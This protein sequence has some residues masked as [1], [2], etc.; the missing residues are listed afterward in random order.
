MSITQYSS[1]KMKSYFR[2]IVSIFLFLS[3]FIPP[4]VFSSPIGKSSNSQ[5]SFVHSQKSK[6]SSPNSSFEPFECD[7]DGSREKSFLEFSLVFVGLLEPLLT[8]RDHSKWQCHIQ[9]NSFTEN[10]SRR[11]TIRHS[12]N[13]PPIS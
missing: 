1:A 5:I 2:V 11:L 8:S 7:S 3:F 6:H 9:L 12:L 10:I 4:E 13:S